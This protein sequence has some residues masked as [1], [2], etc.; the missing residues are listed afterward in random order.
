MRQNALT[1]A[2]DDSARDN[3]QRWIILG[4]IY[5]C[6]LAY[7]VTLQ[8]V[9]PVLSLIMPDMHLSHA[10]G[11]LLMS[12]FALPGLIVSI[13]AGL[14]ADRYGQKTIGLVSLLLLILGSTVVATAQSFAILALGRVFSGI[15]GITL[16]VIAPQLLAQWFN[17]RRLGLALGLYNTVFPL[18]T[19]SSLN[20]FSRLGD[21]LGWRSCIWVSVG[22]GVIALLVFL[23]L[24]A[25]AP[26]K[27]QAAPPEP[28][29]FYRDLRRSGTRIWLVA[30]GW[31]L[32]NAGLLS[33]LTFTPDLLTKQGY[34]AAYAGFLTSLVMCP[35][36]ILN[37]IIGYVTS[38][39]GR[40][41][42]IIGIGGII[43]AS[44][45]VWVPLAQEWILPLVLILGI[46]QTTVP[47]P[48]TVL[49]AHVMEPGQW[50]LGYGIIAT[51]Q[52]I[53]VL[54]GPA[55]AGLVRDTTGSYRQSYLLLALFATL[56]TVMM[57]VLSVI[58]RRLRQK[59]DM[60]NV[61]K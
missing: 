37:P 1:Q 7:T 19:V 27:V 61:R 32:F 41:Q 14:L 5:I 26:R 36:L 58:S 13:P 44:L 45:V 23:W 9:P 24:Y 6:V 52:N 48:T 34:S 59:T 16:T 40:M 42:L 35:A 53:G 60:I 51:A 25:P 18:G 15:G 10:Q 22:L 43:W 20:L 31:M 47:A 55:A 12:F 39:V 50:G 56:I 49:A 8:S 54:I 29:S 46:L 57:I 3:R 2:E 28:A 11:G 38:R 21:N 30:A 4:V 33:L 17:G